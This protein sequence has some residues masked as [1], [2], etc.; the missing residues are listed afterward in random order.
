MTDQCDLVVVGAGICGVAAA[1][2]AAQWGL[3]VVIIEKEHTAAVE[4]SGRAQGI[5]RLQGRD[6]AELPLAREAIELWQTVEDP[7]RIEL[8]F[9][10]NLYICDDAELPTLRQMVA[11]AT[12]AG[13]GGVELLSADQAREIVPAARGPFA[14][15]MWSPVDGHCQPDK[16]TQYVLDSALRAG[17]QVRF[18]TKALALDVRGDRVRG[19]RTDRGDVQAGAVVVAGG[20]WTPHLLAAHGVNVPVMP[21]ALSEREIGPLPPVFTPAVRAFG[22]GGRQRPD[23]RIV[24]SNGLNAVVDHRLS[25]YDLRFGRLWA[26]RLGAHWRSVRL[27]LGLRETFGQLRHRTLCSTALVTSGRPGPPSRPRRLDAAA[28]SMAAVFPDLR[29]APVVRSWA[30]LVDMSPDGL[31]I[32]DTQLSGLAFV[33]GLSGHGFTLGPAIGR[34]LADLAIEGSTARPVENFGLARFDG[35]VPVPVPQKTI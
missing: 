21:V 34:A 16:A 6:P 9:G 31:P 18:S 4:G 26:R 15:A 2:A 20:V 17:A 35:P 30:G 5:L 27:R 29:G 7:A 13:L 10:G 28:R 25:L 32:I 12:A 23:G 33:T 24:L 3:D 19:V 11:E 8:V 1:E 14:G 22:F